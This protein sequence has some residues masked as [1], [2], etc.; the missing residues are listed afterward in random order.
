MAAA[1]SDQAPGLSGP[2]N[3]GPATKRR[4]TGKK[5]DKASP[6]TVVVNGCGGPRCAVEATTKWTILHVQH[7]IFQQISVP[8]DW[9][10]LIKGTEKL[11]WKVTVESLIAEGQEK[12]ELTLIAVEAPDPEP[13]A[14][15]KAMSMSH[16]GGMAKAL[17]LLQWPRLPGLNNLENGETVLHAAISWSLPEIALATAR[18]PDYSRINAADRWGRTALHHAAAKGSLSVCRAILSRTD[19]TELLAED[20]GER[21]ALQLARSGGHLAVLK[22]LKEAGACLQE[23]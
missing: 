2:N 6:I 7:A 21:T 8:M 23:R 14:L 15:L 9:Q 20:H 18:R 17:R 16:R 10:T 4:R 12:L 22:L 3:E 19:F 11:D 13:T 1:S 5:K